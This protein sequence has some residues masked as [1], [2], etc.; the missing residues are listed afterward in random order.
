MWGFTMSER[1]ESLPRPVLIAVVGGL[2]AIALLFVTR[3][4]GNEEVVSPAAPVEQQQQAGSQAG[5]QAKAGEAQPGGAG[6]G[7]AEKSPPR[8]LPTRVKNALDAHKVV[9]VMFYN[10]K[11]PDDLSVKSA[12]EGISTRG[13]KV[14]TVTEKLDNVARY[15][16]LTGQQTVNQTPTVIVVDPQGNGRM[17]TGFRDQETV[18]QL[19][20]DALH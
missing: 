9:A 3:R 18:D 4:G 14:V 19:V 17:A 12:V 5:T 6:A 13:G 10:P 16:R 1:L 7:E 11:S 8:T 20:V 15:T 2:A